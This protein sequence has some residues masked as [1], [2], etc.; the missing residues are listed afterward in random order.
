M[1]RD[2]LLQ[3]LP[4]RPMFLTHRIR[5]LGLLT[6]PV[7]LCVACAV[8]EPG[9]GPDPLG[10]PMAPRGSCFISKYPHGWYGS[11][12]LKVNGDQEVV[13]DSVSL[14]GPR[15]LALVGAYLLPSSTYIQSTDAP[16]QTEKDSGEPPRWRWTK[17]TSAVG[18]S[19]A[20]QSVTSQL[21][22]AA[23]TEGPGVGSATGIEL[24]YH[25]ASGHY[26]RRDPFEIVMGAKRC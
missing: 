15:N 17:R 16:E 20:P 12:P 18:A 23:Q 11:G 22:V 21:V 2:Y 13:V 10:D 9:G 19:L 1:L 24:R 8:P 14:L 25:D 7:I 26:V 3:F 5:Q 4:D 6:L